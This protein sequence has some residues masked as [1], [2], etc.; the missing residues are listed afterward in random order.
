ME[1]NPECLPCMSG[2]GL[3]RGYQGAVEALLGAPGALWT[4]YIS[5]VPCGQSCCFPT[6]APL[7]Y[8]DATALGKDTQDHSSL[9]MPRGHSLAL[10]H[11][12]VESI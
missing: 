5:C 3:L 9:W 7:L 11:L 8:V 6:P 1:L 4:E 10:Q 2:L 12:R